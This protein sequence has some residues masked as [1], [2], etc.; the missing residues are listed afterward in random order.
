MDTPTTVVKRLGIK[1]GMRVWVGG[2][3]TAARTEI[4]SHLVGTD[5]PPEGPIDLGFITPQS[6]DEAV[7]FAGK[8]R[9]RLVGPGVLWIVHP[10]HRSP[11][12]DT[13][14]GNL[15]DLAVGLFELGFA[16]V[17]AAPVG[18]DFTSLGFRRDDA[19]TPTA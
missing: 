3:N 18:N 16:Q 10:N 1:P 19:L 4:E 17:G 15:D 9:R 2:H 14:T 5:R 7:Y 8:L 13:F 6:G 11:H 12:R